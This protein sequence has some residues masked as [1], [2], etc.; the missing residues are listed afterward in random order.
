MSEMEEHRNLSLGSREYRN[1]VIYIKH[2]SLRLFEIYDSEL[3]LEPV[4]ERS[5]RQG[6]NVFSNKGMK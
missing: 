1:V 5:R 3:G 4:A 6:M 2:M